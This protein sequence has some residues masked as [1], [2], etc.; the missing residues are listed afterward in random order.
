MKG[1]IKRLIFVFTIELLALTMYATGQDGDIIYIDGKQWILLGKPVYADS[2]LRNDLMTALPE[3]RSVTTANW[4]GYTAYWSISQGELCLDSIK[5]DLYDKAT[6]LSHTERMPSDIMLRMFKKYVDGN[7]IVASWFDNDLRVASGEMIYYVHGGYER[8]Y[9]YEQIISIDHGKLTGKQ[10]YH[11]Y[12]VDGFSFDNNSPDFQAQLRE[13]FPLHIENYPELANVKATIV[14]TIDK[15][16]ERSRNI[17][18]GNKAVIDKWLEGHPYLKQY[19]EA[20]GTTYLIHYDIDMS[21]T[22][23]GDQLIDEKGTVICQGDCFEMPHTFRITLSHAE[24]LEE[25]LR[26][27]DEFLEEKAAIYGRLSEK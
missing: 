25:G 4:D 13:K 15:I 12:V 23:F 16:F 11:N 7:R 5:Y 21:A 19:A 14:K 17:V 27:I 9:E 22:D 3:G 8:N 1:M 6:K 24:D 26:R 2:V 18:N 10:A 20:H